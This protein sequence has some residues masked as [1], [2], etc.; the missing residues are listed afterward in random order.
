ML[1]DSFLGPGFLEP[2]TGSFLFPMK[3][4]IPIVIGLLVVGCGQKTSKPEAKPPKEL[5]LEEKVV[6]TYGLTEGVPSLI[7]QENGMVSYYTLG[8]TKKEEVKWEIQSGEIVAFWKTSH[9][10]GN[11]TSFYRIEA[12]GDISIIANLDSDGK[13]IEFVVHTTFEK[14]K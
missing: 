7:F 13:R 2:N 9:G 4:L 1:G 12:N 3:T 8:G 5:T 6:G 14:L 10:G 11:G